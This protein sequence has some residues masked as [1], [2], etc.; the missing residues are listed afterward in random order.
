MS[1]PGTPSPA[2]LTAM[3]SLSG[4]EDASRREAWAARMAVDAEAQ[5]L[6]RAAP[7]PHA[8]GPVQLE[9]LVR[10]SPDERRGAVLDTVDGARLVAERVRSGQ[11]RA[12]DR[13]AASLRTATEATRLN[14]L[15][16]L[17]EEQATAE[18]EA[19]DAAVLRGDDAGPL[20]G[21]TVA[22]KDLVAVR[23]HATTGGTRALDTPP[24]QQDADCVSRL[25]DAGAVVV[26]MSNLHGLAYGVL[27]TNPDFGRVHNPHRPEALAGGS[28][29]G[30]AAAVAAGIVDIAIGTDTAG[31]IRIP[32]A[33]CGVVGLK[34]TYGRVSTQGVLPLARTLD[35]VGPLA[36]T[37][38]DVALAFE[39]LSP[40]PFTATTAL[41]TDL[42]GV[43][44]GVPSTYFLDHLAP[45]VRAALQSARAAVSAA[46]G[47][48][49][50]VDLPAM[51]HAPAAQ[52]FTLAPEAFEVHRDLVRERG[53]LLP[54]DVRV[55]VEMGMFFLGAD[56]V[57][58]QRLRGLLQRQVDSAFEHV[59]ALL[60]PTL[61]T[62]APDA[63]ATSVEVQ[64]AVWPTQFAL[65]RLTM[66]FNATGHPAATLPWGAD[67]RHVPL[68]LQVA[69]RAMDEATVLGVAHVLE[70]ARA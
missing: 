68:G 22:V 14:A 65:T 63:D 46:G 61:A 50:D 40:T 56:Y 70:Q 26:A 60:T 23:G 59:D 44:V 3:A 39:A 29:G 28:S 31:S 53:H 11:L 52:L 10:R 2:A 48:V 35:T 66:P 57:R 12:A 5:E 6:L 15:T 32:A 16:H 45:E 51:R 55:R 62:P 9:G 13:V 17:F 8:Q 34:P 54:E 67:D 38:A 1:G 69:G 21:L 7:V 27:S 19:L 41:W 20:A 30:S 4:V 18:A 36:R 43:T 49:V 25:R 37:V 64:G 58:A 33:C 42:S 47:R 24:A